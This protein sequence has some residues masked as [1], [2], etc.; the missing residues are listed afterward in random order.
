MVAVFRLLFQD[1]PGS[2]M[3]DRET[4]LRLAISNS[5]LF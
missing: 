4:S 5:I 1:I 3:M 2:L